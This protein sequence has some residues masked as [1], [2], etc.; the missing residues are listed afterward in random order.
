[1]GL[2]LFIVGVVMVALGNLFGAM[3]LQ[4]GSTGLGLGLLLGLPG[5]LSLLPLVGLWIGVGRDLREVEAE[6]ENERDV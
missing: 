2:V 4:K 3:F 5:A 1:M 6:V